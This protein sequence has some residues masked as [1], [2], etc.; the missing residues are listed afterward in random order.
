MIP[1]ETFIY[2]RQVFAQ[3]WLSEGMGR[4]YSEVQEQFDKWMRGEP[5]LYSEIPRPT[6]TYVPPI[7]HK[8]KFVSYPSGSILVEQGH[9]CRCGMP[10]KSMLHE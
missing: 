2:A 6:Q 5:V 9:C 7:S 1:S 3:I 10:E 8:H 4:K